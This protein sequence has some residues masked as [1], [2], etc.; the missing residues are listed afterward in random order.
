MESHAE[1]VSKKMS[2]ITNDHSTRAVHSTGDPHIASKIELN[3]IR[4][5]FLTRAT[6]ENNSH[7]AE[8]NASLPALV[9]SAPRTAVQE[10]F[11][12][13]KT[14]L[15]LEE[16]VLALEREMVEIEREYKRRMSEN[17]QK[18]KLAR[19]RLADH[20]KLYGHPPAQRAS[21]PENDE[22]TSDPEDTGAIMPCRHNTFMLTFLALTQNISSHTRKRPV[23]T[24]STEN[25]SL[26]ERPPKRRNVRAHDSYIEI[27]SENVM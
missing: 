25:Q 27:G 20:R 1:Y 23:H 7:T 4:A 17:Q 8:I 24:N 6:D 18:L 21:S 12:V 19:Q 5:S 13:A 22:H 26:N 15:Q 3:D 9:V 11:E 14:K 2:P 16:T 10:R